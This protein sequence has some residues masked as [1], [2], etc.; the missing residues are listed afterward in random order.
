MSFSSLLDG[1]GQAVEPPQRV[2]VAA[3]HWT[4][5]LDAHAL[6]RERREHD[7]ALEPRHQLADAHVNAGAEADMAR[8]L[9]TD[10]VAIRLLP[11]PRIAGGGAQEHKHLLA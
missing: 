5:D 4:A 9:A 10:I 2:V 7:L 1:D 11:A 8:C 3:L 6:A